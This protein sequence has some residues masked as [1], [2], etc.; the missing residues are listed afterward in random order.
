MYAIGWRDH[1]ATL[2]AN[3]AYDPVSNT[4]SARVPMPT[5]R[6]GL[7]AAAVGS[8]IYA[9]CGHRY[10]T[11]YCTNEAFDASRVLFVHI[12]N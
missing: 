8:T 11:P 7:A 12:K 6:S 4:W 1:C 10:G 3:E 5:A 2:T 9:I